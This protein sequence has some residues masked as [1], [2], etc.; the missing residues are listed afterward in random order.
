MY[1]FNVSQ[2]EFIQQAIRAREIVQE[3]T[4]HA[5]I[6]HAQHLGSL[7]PWLC[8]AH[9]QAGVGIPE[10]LWKHLAAAE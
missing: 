7:P 2:L 9:D 8:P 6:I 5:R 10:S 4:G 3:R 1:K